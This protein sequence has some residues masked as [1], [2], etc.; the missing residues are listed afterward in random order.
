[1]V[2]GEPQV[3][4]AADGFL[5]QGLGA[6]GTVAQESILGS[7]HPPSVEKLQVVLGLISRIRLPE[8]VAV[9]LAGTCV[10]FQCSRGVRFHGTAQQGQLWPLLL[11]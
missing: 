11:G 6:T 10:S 7:G 9:T 3:L 2:W 5:C 8:Q 1:M 4:G